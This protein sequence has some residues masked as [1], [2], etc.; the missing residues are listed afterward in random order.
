M[1][2]LGVSSVYVESWRPSCQDLVIGVSENLLTLQSAP[3]EPS[4][5]DGV[6]Y[7]SRVVIE[8]NEHTYA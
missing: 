5:A 8:R 7:F 2:Y 6:L 3:A 1:M 4:G